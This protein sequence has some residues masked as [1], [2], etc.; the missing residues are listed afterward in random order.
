MYPF[1]KMSQAGLPRACESRYHHSRKQDKSKLTEVLPTVRFSKIVAAACLAAGFTAVSFAQTPATPAPAKR[2]AA[3]ASKSATGPKPT[4]SPYDRT[5]L[6][7]SLL[8][9]KA[10]DTYQAKFETTRGDFTIT[11]TRAYSPLGADRFY[12]LVRHHFF[13]DASF[14]RV[15][16]NFVV[17]FGISAYP[18]VT[19]AWRTATIKDDPR[20]QSNKR[21]TITF[22]TSGPNTRTTELFINLKDNDF[23]DSKGFTPFCSVDDKGMNVVEFFYDQYYQVNP[24][25]REGGAGM[26]QQAMEQGGKKYIDTKWPKLDSIKRATL[27]GAAATAPATKPAPRKPAATKPTAA[28]AKP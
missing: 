22:A 16:P 3:T 17:Q 23:L 6:K 5:L 8:K 19:A 10:P 26:D 12:N 14:F 11:C 9:D 18:P 20:N 24:D 7:P 21:G 27:I 28:P 1:V 15:V 13:D 4:R 25:G 2:K